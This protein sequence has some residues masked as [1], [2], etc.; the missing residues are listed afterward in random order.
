MSYNVESAQ[1]ELWQEF[2][3]QRVSSGEVADIHAPDHGILLGVYI[4]FKPDIH[5]TGLS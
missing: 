1:A 3:L 5:T 2:R 4:P